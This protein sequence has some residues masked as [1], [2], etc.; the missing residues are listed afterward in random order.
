MMLVREISEIFPCFLTANP[1]AGGAEAGPFVGFFQSKRAGTD[2]FQYPVGILF[3]GDI[4]D[5]RGS[6]KLMLGNQH[7]VGQNISCIAGQYRYFGL[8]EHWSVVQFGGH[9]V[10][11]ATCMAVAR[12]ES[13]LIGV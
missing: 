7:A 11:G 2:L 13:A 6:I 9:K 5:E 10:Y 8:R 3:A 1:P 4:T 12:V